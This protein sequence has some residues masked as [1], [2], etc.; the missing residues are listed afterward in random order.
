MQGKLIEI[1][2]ILMNEI[3]RRGVEFDQMEILS[4]K[5]LNQGY[6]EREISTAFS[7]VIERMGE[8]DKSIEPRPGSFRILHDIEKVFISPEAYGYLLQLYSLKL[9]NM[10]EM[11]R[12][13]EKSVISSSPRMKIEDMKSLVIDV[14]FDE[15]DAFMGDYDSFM[16]DDIIQ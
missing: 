6:S 5:L 15:E 7:W 3:N 4:D 16:P 8:F 13:I 9:L 12:I 10:D 2:I 1:L 11:E 14:L